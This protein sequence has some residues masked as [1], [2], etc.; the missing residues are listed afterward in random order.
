[1]GIGTIPSGDYNSVLE[2]DGN[3]IL[4]GKLLMSPTM[5]GQGGIYCEYIYAEGE[6][7]P[8]FIYANDLSG[9]VITG[10]TIT[11]EERLEVNGELFAQAITVTLEDFPDYVFSSTYK[12]KSLPE[13]EEY[14]VKNGKLPN[15]PSE[16]EVKERGLNLGEM[17]SKLLE[18]IEEMTLHMIQMQ[19]RIDELE[20]KHSEMK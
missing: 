18:K 16:D 14:I 3:V 15:I 5:A 11:A 17:Q 4:N 10:G 2:T 9:D 12:L 8:G 13:I 7:I 20:A 6:E 19:K 1:V